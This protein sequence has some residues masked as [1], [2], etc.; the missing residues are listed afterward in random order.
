[1]TDAT[2]Y[3]S[4]LRRWAERLT[5]ASLLLVFFSLGN[6]RV[7]FVLGAA[8]AI[9]TW[10]VS[11]Q[12]REKIL[13]LRANPP[14]FLALLLVILIFAQAP[15]SVGSTDHVIYSL[16]VAWKLL[17]IPVIATTIK[18]E[19]D[20]QRCWDFFAA[21]MVVVLAYVYGEYFQLPWP[22]RA[23]GA[24]SV[25]YNPLPQSVALAMF[26]LYCVNIIA[27][28][29]IGGGLKA[30]FSILLLGAS[31]AIFEI[32]QQRL[33]YLVFFLG[34]AVLICQRLSNN[35]R[36]L[37]IGGPVVMASL[38]VMSS[39]K[40]QTRLDQARQEVGSYNFKPHY[41]SVGGRLHMW[42]SAWQNIKEQP[43]LGHG[44]G[45]YTTLAKRSF[46]DDTM[47]AIGCAH[48]HNQ[49]AQLWVENGIL[50]LALYLGIFWAAGKRNW[51]DRRTQALAIPVMSVLFVSGFFDTLLWYRG[52]VYLFIPLLGLAIVTTGANEPRQKSALRQPAWE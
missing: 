6:S 4:K 49:F 36:W 42:Y 25:F 38:V 15:W 11:G 34:L 31:Y 40:I 26:S 13:A 1:M 22:N 14:A 35:R 3:Q 23:K 30:A 2:S 7:L 48:P 47:C 5:L 27:C 46:N 51:A 9:G 20:L 16:D 39:S 44:T 8:L 28:H 17:L 33:G 24:A 41:S 37:A 32:S 19:R 45:S 21:G 18:T 43:L 50:G 12:Y 29:R 52:W 10:I